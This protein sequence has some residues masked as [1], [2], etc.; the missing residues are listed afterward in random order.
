MFCQ[1]EKLVTDMVSVYA[2]QAVA[3]AALADSSLLRLH[4]QDTSVPALME[5]AGYSD[6]SPSDVAGNLIVFVF[7]N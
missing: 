4:I 1:V 7:E 2:M 6:T 5:S 3:R